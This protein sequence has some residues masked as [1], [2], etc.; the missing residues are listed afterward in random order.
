MLQDLSR[1]SSPTAQVSTRRMQLDARHFALPCVVKGSSTL[2]RRYCGFLPRRKRTKITIMYVCD[3]FAHAHYDFLEEQKRNRSTH[4]S[5]EPLNTWEAVIPRFSSSRQFLHACQGA[6]RERSLDPS[7]PSGSD[8]QEDSTILGTHDRSIQ[9]ACS[10]RQ[11]S[12]CCRIA[13]ES[14]WPVQGLAYDVG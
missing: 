7:T 9:G 13:T 14:Y 1:A 11:R 12:P 2:P 4:A 6:N 3:R 10:S 5:V 8:Q